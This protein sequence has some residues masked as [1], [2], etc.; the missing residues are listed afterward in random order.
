MQRCLKWKDFKCSIFS[1][2]NFSKRWNANGFSS[3]I[4]FD[5]AEVLNV[6]VGVLIDNSSFLKNVNVSGVPTE[7]T[8]I[9]STDLIIDHYSK[10]RNTVCKSY[11]YESCCTTLFL[12]LLV[13]GEQKFCH[14]M[15]VWYQWTVATSKCIKTG[16][17]PVSRPVEQVHYFGGCGEGV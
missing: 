8:L 7:R 1:H 5:H 4:K 3:L 9:N 11:F 2:F 6:C 10:K 17:Q 15:Q 12:N 16:L 14:R 13:V